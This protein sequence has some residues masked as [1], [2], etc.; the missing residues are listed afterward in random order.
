MAILMPALQRVRNQAKSVMCQAN[1]KQWGLVWAMY[2]DE[3]SGKFPD[4]LGGNWMQILVDYYSNSHKLLY[5]PATSKTMEEGAPVRYAV[6]GTA[7]DPRGSYALNEWIYDSDDTGG[8][9]SL[10]DYWRNINHTGLNNVPVMGDGAWRS[11]G[12]PYPT[13]DPPEFEGQARSGVGTGGDEMRIFC[14]NRH[15]S[16]V[17]ILFMDWSTRRVG[18]KELWTLKWHVNFDIAGPW[19]MA[20][21]VAGNDWPVWMRS[22]KDY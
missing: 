7:D 13:D 6:I 11:D 20:G 1:L 10:E 2:A 18:L 21:L 9:R 16:A 19:T 8:G 15:N 5:C 3:N 17:N 12:Q 22:F 4:Y 14:I